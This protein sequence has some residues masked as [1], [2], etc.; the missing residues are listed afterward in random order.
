MIIGLPLYFI[1]KGRVG[2]AEHMSY[3]VVR[4]L[5]ASG[6]D[7]IIACSSCLD[8][9]DAFVLEVKDNAKCEFLITKKSISRF[10]SE[11]KAS[12]L[13]SR[14]CDGVIYPNYF[15][16][17]TVLLGRAKIITVIHDLQYIHFPKYFPLKK[18][19]WLRLTHYF[20][21]LLADD[22]V[23][24]S[25][26]VKKDMIKCYGKW[27]EKKITVI[28]NPIS[29]DR[30][31]SDEN[32]MVA[33]ERPYIL[34]VA[35]DYP[36]K[37]LKTILDVFETIYHLYPELSLVLVGQLSEQVAGH[38][39]KK[40][41]LTN[42]IKTL[43]S[44]DRI[45]ITGYL[46]DKTLG[47]L[48]RSAKVFL[49]PSLFEGF[50]MP[51]VEA[52]G[53]GKPVITSECTAIKETTLGYASKYIKEPTNVQEWNDA[54]KKVLDFSAPNITDEQQLELKQA[55]LPNYIAKKYVQVF[56]NQNDNV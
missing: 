42:Y 14:K 19:L 29:W 25:N 4:G 45:V 8:L 49:F 24:I 16:P 34:S 6:H 43:K 23:A 38:I 56:L 9:D 53:F 40:S 2:G 44:K 12:M 31:D 27:C 46:N 21:L 52:L 54:I 28:H 18:R 3:N 33:I 36:H 1:K 35:A 13:L 20:T 55:Y 50:G 7:V 41:P 47:E 26:F 37:N 39:N 30:F 48:Y 11:I 15:T 32:L 10:I 17:P 51:P 22:V 5:L